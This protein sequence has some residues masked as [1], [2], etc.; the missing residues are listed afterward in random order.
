MALDGIF[1][2]FLKNEIEQNAVGMRVEKVHQ[3]SKEELVLILRGREGGKKLFLS[4][5]ANSPRINFTQ[6]PPE[7]PKTPAMICML[8]RKKLTNAMITGIRQPGCDRVLFID[9]DAANEIG[10][11]IR[12]SLCIEIMAQYSN[13]IL[14]DGENK[15][16]DS[17]KRVDFSTSSVRQIL[18]G[19]EYKL[20]PPQNKIDMTVEPSETI[21]E[22]ILSFTSKELS[23][24]I[25]LSV[26]G[27]SPVVSREISFLT[28]GNDKIVSEMTENEKSKLKI[29]L[30]NFKEK[31]SSPDAEAFILYDSD[32]KPVD[33]SF[34]EIKQ[35]GSM[36]KCEKVENFSA[37]LDMF[38]FERDRL[39]RTKQRSDDLYKM[40]NSTLARIS[41]KL[42][43]QR[44]DLKRSGE[45]ENL[46]IYGELISANQ[47]RL[48][49]GVSFYEV[50][51]Y[52]DNNNIL[53]IPVNPALNPA[54]NSQKYYK[55]YRKA[56]TAHQVLSQLIGQGEAE[57]EYIESV[58]DEL[59][60]SESEDELNEIRREL[61][62]NG[63]LKDKSKNPKKK[64]TKTLPFREYRTEDGFR[65]L[66]GRN[67]VQNDKLSLKTAMKNDMWL[68]TQK[69][70]GSHVIICSEN[71][72]IT[73]KSIEEAAVIAAYHSKARSSSL[74]PVDYTFVKNLKKPIG[75]KPGTVIYH[76]YNTIIVNPDESKVLKSEIK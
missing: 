18:P 2:S 58:I 51:N 21:C 23:N 27:I 19:I 28:L 10:D 66:V 34:T 7:N 4:S 6:Y 53:K 46:R 59:N 54:A 55:E 31:I 70:H 42:N 72:E 16:I 20:P 48:E 32:G 15:I 75:A 60:R 8:L 74:V 69:I 36:R 24:A 25:L 47:Y 39:L 12:L 38:Y 50:E 30:E 73:D 1:L 35:Y 13:I 41:K 44:E 63:Y 61:T 26:K 5:R 71:R 67:N 76:V 45:R 40:L 14:I 11:K 9:F 52:Y 43:L 68:H 49:K 17:L 62:E 64:I 22:K 3:P 57:L 29:V 65:V 37:L 33:F 56:K